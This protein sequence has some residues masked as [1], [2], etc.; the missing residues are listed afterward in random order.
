M[1]IWIGNMEPGTTDDEIKTFFK[2]YAADL[3]CVE[4]ERVEG[5]GSRPAA[6]LRFSGATP[7]YLGNLAIRLNGMY[8]KGRPLACNTLMR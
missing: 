7:E 2:K 5:D 6:M 1:R 8:W 4:L 3:E